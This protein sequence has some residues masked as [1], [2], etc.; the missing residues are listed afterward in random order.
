[1]VANTLRSIGLQPELLRELLDR[2]AFGD[3][4]LLAFREV[5]DIFAAADGNAQQLTFAIALAIEDRA[6]AISLAAP[7]LF[8]R[9]NGGDFG[10]QRS[11]GVQSTPA[12]KR[13]AGSGGPRPHQRLAGT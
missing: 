10:A 4:D 11:G 6:R 1:M 7:L 5:G 13:A 2:D 12:A 9:R 8:G 3:R